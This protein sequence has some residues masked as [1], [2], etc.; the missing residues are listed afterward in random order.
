MG[1]EDNIY[2]KSS[3]VR[4]VLEG[5]SD[6][7]N[8]ILNLQLDDFPRP[9]YNK[10]AEKIDQIELGRLL[11]LILGCAVNCFQKQKYITQIMQLEESLQ[12]NI[13]QTLQELDTI[14][15]GGQS[16]HI[17]SATAKGGGVSFDLEN[18]KDKLAERCYA[19]ESQIV[20]LLEEKQ[21]MQQE[22]NKLQE[23]LNKV[24]DLPILGSLLLFI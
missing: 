10:I 20:I 2:L 15:Q 18:I 19:A 1:V 17:T 13:M 21:I 5:C 23:Q 7:Y 16:G 6:Y 12:R 14:S 11:Q 22:I 8:E 4:K 24:D 3:N 9:D